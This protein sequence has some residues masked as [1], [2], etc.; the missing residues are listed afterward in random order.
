MSLAKG[1]KAGIEL[2]Y[3][4]LDRTAES[5]FRAIQENINGYFWDDLR[6][7][8][9]AVNLDSAATRYSFNTTELGIQFDTNAR[10]PNE[11]VNF[12]AQMPHSKLFGSNAHVH[13]H[14]MQAEANLPNVLLAHR[15]YNNNKAIPSTWTFSIMK[16]GVFTYVSGNL[17]QISEIA[18]ATPPVNEDVSSI[19]EMKLW[20]DTANTTGYF[21]GADPY[22]VAWLFKELDLHIQFDSIGSVQEYDKYRRT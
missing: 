8:A 16:P 19:L 10:H 6:F 5:N 4:G 13:I 7:P 14:W 9:T 12:I 21:A 18:V 17:A 1:A 22:T 11:Q 3:H 15:W 20:R 2:D